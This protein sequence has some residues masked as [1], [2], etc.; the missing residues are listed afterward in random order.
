MSR[1]LL[2]MIIAWLLRVLKAM[3]SMG[4]ALL[5]TLRRTDPATH[6]DNS[7]TGNLPAVS[8]QSVTDR[9]LAVPRR[10]SPVPASP[11]QVTKYRFSQRPLVYKPG[12]NKMVL[13]KKGDMSY[14]R[15]SLPIGWIKYT[16]PEGAP[17]YLHE[18]KRIIT[19]LTDVTELQQLLEM[20]DFLLHSAR[21]L[22][23]PLHF[24]VELVITEV[25]GPK[26]EKVFGYYFVDHRQRLLFW[27]HDYDLLNIFFSVDGV[28]ARDHMSRASGYNTVLDA[29]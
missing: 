10:P 8:V 14:D 22:M 21:E 6:P 23:L 3:P 29:H 17:Y 26:G 5:R 19:D 2:S 18:E 27:V 20:A 1:A 16:Q 12:S 4:C 24:D 9:H 25:L 15:P 28:T 13:L 7:M 11:Q